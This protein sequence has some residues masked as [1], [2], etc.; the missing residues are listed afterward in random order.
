MVHVLTCNGELEE[1]FRGQIQQVDG[2]FHLGVAPYVAERMIAEL[3]DRMTEMSMMG[4][5]PVFLVSPEL[6]RPVRN[7]LERFLPQLMVISHKEVAHGIQIHSEG[8]IGAGLA[9]L[10]A[11]AL[12]QH[13]DQAGGIPAPA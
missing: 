5:Q 6:R 3:E 13:G 7:L 8:E 4:L 10:I 12:P 1:A 9:E 2:D 11:P